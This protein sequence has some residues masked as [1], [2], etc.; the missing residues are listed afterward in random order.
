[1]RAE[2]AQHASVIQLSCFLQAKNDIFNRTPPVNRSISR[3]DFVVT[4][5]I[6][7]ETP[8]TPVKRLRELKE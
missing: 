1:M 3:S 7:G 4:P 5:G 2:R 8:K 6:N